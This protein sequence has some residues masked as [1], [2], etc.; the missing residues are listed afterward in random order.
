MIGSEGEVVVCFAPPSGAPT[1]SSPFGQPP[2]NPYGE[3]PPGQPPYGAPVN[4]YQHPVGPPGYGVYGKPLPPGTVKNWL[5]ES[6][7]S[8]ICCGGMLAI[9]AVIFAAQV[10]GHLA[11]GDYRAAVEAS[12]NAKLWLSIA[13]GVAIG[14]FVLCGVPMIIIQFMAAV[15]GAR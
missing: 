2:Y 12:N 6:I 13:V 10:D 8:L 11:R 4:P 7:L 14:F 3:P 15:A 9:P 5:I 1:M